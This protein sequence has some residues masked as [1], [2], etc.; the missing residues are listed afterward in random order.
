MSAF[1]AVV[2]GAGPNGLAAGIRLAQAGCSVLVVEAAATIGGSCRSSEPGRPGVVHDPGAGVFPMAV[3]SP[4]F[5]ALPL[6]AHGLEWIQPEVPLAHPLH[7]SPAALLE[8]S[9]HRTRESLGSAGESWVDLFAPLHERVDEW[10]SSILGPRSLPKPLLPALRFG[11]SAIRSATSLAEKRLAGAAARALFAG[12]AAHGGLPLDR[13]GTAG[14]GLVLGVAG[15]A[16]GWPI[17]RGGA[18]QLSEALGSYFRS[19]GGEIW[20]GQRISS[21]S[22]LPAASVALLDLTPVQVLRVAGERLPSSYRRSLTRYRYGPGVFKIGWALSAPIPWTDPGVRRAGTV[23]LGGSSSEIAESL[24]WTARGKVPSRPFVILSQPSLFDS[25]RAPP[26]LHTAWG[27]CHVPLASEAPAVEEIEAQ[28]ERFAPGFRDAILERHVAGPRELEL[29]NP[30]IV[31]GDILG[32]TSDLRQL[33]LRPVARFDPYSTPAPGLYI[34]SSATPPGSGVHGM[35]GFNAAE[36]I[37]KRWG[38]ARPMQR[39]APG[40]HHEMPC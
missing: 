19:L 2:V 18:Q 34:C 16:V 7:D 14:I 4:F 21:L 24:A 28:V 36:A 35:C 10:T 11:C 12:I 9:I 17:P 32:G 15:H 38:G 22:E 13:L 8:R 33:L 25:S 27:Y 1:D 23:H 6:Q 37:L 20:T 26:G 30:N 39:N 29:W 40:F 31:G 5:R 3:L